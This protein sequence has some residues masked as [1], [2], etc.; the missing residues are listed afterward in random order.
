MQG[1]VCDDAAT[2]S[3]DLYNLARADLFAYTS[4]TSHSERLKKLGIV[5]DIKFCLKLNITNVIPFLQGEKLV[6]L[7]LV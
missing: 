6:C 3:Q 2:A 7:S 5:E 4:K 1:Y